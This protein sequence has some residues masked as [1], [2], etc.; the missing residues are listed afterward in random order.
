MKPE[1]QPC[2]SLLM[3][4]VPGTSVSSASYPT[5]VSVVKGKIQI[6]CHI[7]VSGKLFYIYA[8]LFAGHVQGDQQLL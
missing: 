4:C 7:Y 1:P 6:S 5:A 8:F 3:E 2:S